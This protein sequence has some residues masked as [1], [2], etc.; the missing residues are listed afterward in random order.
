M[1][2][3]ISAS[4]AAAA[5]AAPA[6]AQDDISLASEIFVERISHLGD[7]RMERRIEPA[8]RLTRGDKVI[9]MVE[10]RAPSAGS[11][12]SV[13]S[14]IPGTLAFQ[15]ASLDHAEVSADGGRNWGK[16]G[17]LRIR[18]G[19]SMRLASPGDVTN[20]R[21]RVKGREAARG[22]GR[23]TYSAIVR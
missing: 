18:E 12:F 7:G 16:L 14:P 13:S 21:W 17:Q 10:W 15:G 20:L 5:M 6:C 22:A 1:R 8:S 23:I 4:L 19:R 11:S 3:I 2:C 9:L